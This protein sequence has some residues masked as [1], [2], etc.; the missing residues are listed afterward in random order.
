MRPE[1]LKK[2]PAKSREMVEAYLVALREHEVERI[3]TETSKLA[4]KRCRVRLSYIRGIITDLRKG[5]R[6]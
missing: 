5:G 1:L 4:K 2:L 6:E 3:K